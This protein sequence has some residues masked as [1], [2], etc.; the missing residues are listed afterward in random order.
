MLRS[1][2]GT[3]SRNRTWENRNGPRSSLYAQ[4][5]LPWT[6]ILEMHQQ[7]LREHL[8]HIFGDTDRAGVVPSWPPDLFGAVASTLYL[9]GAYR[10]VVKSWPPASLDGAAWANA[11]K[12]IGLT[13]RRQW[14]NHA[15]R[16]A[17][18]SRV[19]KWWAVL[20]A[21]G[22]VDLLDVHRK[23]D[24][25]RAL[26]QLLA[27]AD[28]ACFGFGT[29]G[30]RVS[31]SDKAHEFAYQV[32]FPKTDNQGAT[33]CVDICPSKLRVLPKLHTPQNGL[34]IR[35]LSHNLAL[36]WGNEVVPH[37]YAVPQNRK[38]SLNLLLIPWP[39]EI[40]PTQFKPVAGSSHPLS[41]LPN[42]YGFFTFELNETESIGRWLTDV[43]VEA[44]RK[45][46]KIDGIVLPELAVTPEQFEAVREL[47]LQEG[48]FLISG[49]AEPPRGQSPA[50]RNL[51][52]FEVPWIP[53]HP[54]SMPEQ[55]KHHRW[56]LED[57]QLHRYGLNDQ[58]P[59]R[60]LRW[61]E[62][63]SIERRT[64]NFV[65]LYDWLT[66]AVLICE[67]LARSDPA[68]DLV[69][70]VGPDLVIALLMD[71]AQVK[72]R[73][74]SRYAS[75]LADDPGC[76][77]L[78]LTSLGMTQLGAHPDRTIALWKEAKKGAPQEITLDS[79]SAAVV[80]KLNLQVIEEWTADGRTDGGTSGYPS[81][82]A[83][84]QVKS[85]TRHA[86]KRA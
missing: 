8:D 22:G 11:I 69:R 45:V 73:W 58:F 44:K 80:L 3:N 49:V 48:I 34:T 13:W 85:K 75:V 74:S 52:R 39:L 84:V 33:L 79:D 82:S 50:G 55:D 23:P 59:Q 66:I 40:K 57:G 63:A 2:E 65:C 35:S 14:T 41:N 24:L 81:L 4:S 5:V 77:V 32:V 83:V 17:V 72:E 64:L 54:I 43:I 70:S 47:V 60:G 18:P 68:G 26:I 27:V 71:G 78:T 9:T 31:E 10:H 36:C 62:Y 1:A 20:L 30:D 25:C 61:W 28:E 7:T 42:G 15:R 37:W 56:Q 16:R 12:K 21:H 46:G 6:L 76:S 67:D 51:V 53:G 19:V 86:V 29:L 38:E